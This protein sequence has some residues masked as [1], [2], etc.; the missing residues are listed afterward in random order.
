MRS[1]V[2][3]T[4]VS[5][6]RTLNHGIENLVPGVSGKVRIAYFAG[7]VKMNTPDTVRKN[8]FFSRMRRVVPVLREGLLAQNAL[9]ASPSPDPNPTPKL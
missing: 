8:M 7:H 4:V 9:K 5:Y 3:V 1:R 2:R 6:T